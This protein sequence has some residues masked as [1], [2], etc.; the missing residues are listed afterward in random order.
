V[1]FTGV[2]IALKRTG[3]SRTCFIH[4][5]D[6]Q[7]QKLEAEFKFQECCWCSLTVLMCTNSEDEIDHFYSDAFSDYG[8]FKSSNKEGTKAD[9]GLSRN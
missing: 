7:L 1:D 2:F 9:F 8:L 3:S 5:D 4:R 6:N